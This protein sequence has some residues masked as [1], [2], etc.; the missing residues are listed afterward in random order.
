MEPPF[1]IRAVRELK[2]VCEWVYTKAE[3]PEDAELPN[4]VKPYEQMRDWLPW[5]VEV[6]D[7][8]DGDG[9][10]RHLKY[11]GSY[12]EQPYFDMCVFRIIRNRW[13]ELRNQEIKAIG[14]SKG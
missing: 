9:A 4:G 12:S 7:F 14:K 3:F 5:I 1:S 8:L 11:P 6:M 10:I 13:N 2:D